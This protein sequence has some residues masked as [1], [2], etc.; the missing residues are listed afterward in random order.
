[1]PRPSTP[2]ILSFSNFEAYFV[3][4]VNIYW[5]YIVYIFIKVK[6]IKI[7]LPVY[8]YTLNPLMTSMIRITTMKMN[9][10][11]RNIWF[12]QILLKKFMTDLTNW[13]QMYAR[14]NAKMMEEIISKAT[15]APESA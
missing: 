10:N 8:S 15:M 11:M 3:V 9:E 4:I 7:L 1:M 13:M 5:R 6:K 14:P 12:L 2:I